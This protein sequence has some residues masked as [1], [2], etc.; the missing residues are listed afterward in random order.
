MYFY[1]D[2]DHKN[3]YISNIL[4]FK[5]NKFL[6]HRDYTHSLFSFIIFNIIIRNLFIK[7]L[8]KN[9]FYIYYGMLIGYLSHIILDL[10]TPMGI[11]LL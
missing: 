9:F 10:F 4:F 3:S 5:I 2:I 1:L 11:N 7:F 8:N 6:K